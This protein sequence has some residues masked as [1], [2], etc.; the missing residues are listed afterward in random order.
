MLQHAALQ[1]ADRGLTPARCDVL[2]SA[3]MTKGLELWTCRLCYNGLLV[4]ELQAKGF[5]QRYAKSCPHQSCVLRGA[6]NKPLLCAAKSAGRGPGAVPGEG[7]R[8]LVDLAR[9]QA[10]LPDLCVTGAT[11]G[12]QTCSSGLAFLRL[13]HEEPG[14][15]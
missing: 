1:G 14:G 8:A 15:S 13:H 6:Q 4:H 7:G 5:R 12:P 2:C 9:G 10:Y 3:V 11:S